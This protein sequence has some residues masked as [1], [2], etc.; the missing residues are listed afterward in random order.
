MTTAAPDVE[1]QLRIDAPPET[2]W[3]FWTHPDHLCE[4]WGRAEAV[5]EVGGAFVV[6]MESGGVM[7][8]EFLALDAPLRLEF[9]FGWDDGGPGGHVPP[10]STRVEVTLE[11]DGDATVLT[12]RHYGLPDDD[13]AVHQEG[14]SHFLP[15]LADRA[16]NAEMDA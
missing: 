2:V 4:W 9:T 8:G 16:T 3:A 13:A 10:G 1:Q 12:L 5:A 11:R 7:R 14:W 6:T 15:I